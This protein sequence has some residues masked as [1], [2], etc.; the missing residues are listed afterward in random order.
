[1]S[2]SFNF[3]RGLILMTAAVHGP[4]GSRAVRLALDTGATETAISRRI[5]VNIGIDI[6]VAPTVP[7]IMG[8]SVVSVPLVTVE[9][10]EALGRT[11]PYLTIQAHTL[12]ASLPIDGVLGLDF[13]RDYRLVVDF[14]TGE[15]S[16][17]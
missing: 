5:L 16:L 11:L 10:L 3:I 2:D 1:V 7:V 13:P 4:R 17:R 15:V 14:R 8:G 9:A 12:P 6:L